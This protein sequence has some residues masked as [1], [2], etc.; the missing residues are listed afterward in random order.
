MKCVLS[1]IESYSIE[2]NGSKYIIYNNLCLSNWR[3][4]ALDDTCS[5]VTCT[6]GRGDIKEKRRGGLSATHIDQA[7]Y[8]LKLTHTKFF[9]ILIFKTFFL[10]FPVYHIDEQG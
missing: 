7:E 4:P 6:N 9:N 10:W 1:T 8:K 3:V 5:D 2:K